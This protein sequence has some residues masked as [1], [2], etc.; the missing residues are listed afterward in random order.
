MEDEPADRERDPLGLERVD[1]QI[2][3]DKLRR[4][5]EEEH[6]AVGFGASKEGDDPAMTESFLETALALE[7]HGFVSP[8]DELK[9]DGFELPAA[10]SLDDES[11]TS[12]MWEL[13]EALAARRMLLHSTNH[14][15]DREL[16]T[17][18]LEE[19]LP[20]E[21]MGFGLPFGSC[22][23]DV[24]GSGSEEDTELQMRFYADDEERA[25]WS[26]DWPDFPMPK[27][28]KPPYDRDR[29]LPRSN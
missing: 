5:L 15:S 25:H 29:L 23:L 24:I 7:K 3:I 22:F 28:E 6:G 11:L 26:A 12:K 19:G 4:E 8:L 16:Y 2:R 27:K 21:T 9:R 18:L 14:L 17:W 10:D 1:Q 13:I 20:E